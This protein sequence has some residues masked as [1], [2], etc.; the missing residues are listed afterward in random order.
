MCIYFALVARI[1][2]DTG[3]SLNFSPM[4]SQVG[5]QIYMKRNS[6]FS[7]N[8]RVHCSNVHRWSQYNFLSLFQK[9]AERR[10]LTPYQHKK[11]AGKQSIIKK[12]RKIGFTSASREVQWY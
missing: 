9:Y 5:V 3:A 1:P 2:V 12:L 4:F 11:K 6:L 10:K 8:E 7:G